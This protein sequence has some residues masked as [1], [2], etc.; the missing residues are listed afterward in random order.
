M[1]DAFG[2]CWV[3]PFKMGATSDKY[4]LIDISNELITNTN[5]AVIIPWEIFRIFDTNTN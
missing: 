2:D 5:E 4:D 3:S 1:L